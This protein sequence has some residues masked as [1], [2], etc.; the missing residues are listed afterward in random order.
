MRE[1]LKGL[2][3]D[4]ETIDSIM[5]EYGKNVQ[6]LKE[7]KEELK[8]K[9]TSYESDIKNLKENSNNVV[10]LQKQLQ[11]YKD[12]EEEEKKKAED[13]RLTDNI[14]KAIGDKKFANDY[15]K[16]GI[17]NEV[18]LEINKEENKGKSYSE[19]FEAITKDKIG[20]FENP[21]KPADIPSMGD[22]GTQNNAKEIPLI[23]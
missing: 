14:L 12:R 17:I 2:E 6:G 19:I 4:K 20:I 21:N 5:A 23:F 15:T 7:E 11:I 22:T 16:N 9:I 8:N 13:E 10:E 3:L 18:K 1:F